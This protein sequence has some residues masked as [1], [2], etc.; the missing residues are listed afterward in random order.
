MQICKTKQNTA[1]AHDAVEVGR[2]CPLFF[3][4]WGRSEPASQ[5][6]EYSCRDV[7]CSSNLASRH[8]VRLFAL[9]LP[10][11]SI[12]KGIFCP[13]QRD[14]LSCTKIIRSHI[15]LISLLYTNHYNFYFQFNIPPLS[16]HGGRW[17]CWPRARKRRR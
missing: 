14:S 17:S 12:L 16:S 7:T 4:S 8:S 10:Y 3:F 11:F 13:G 1:G 5:S 2:A 9:I 6:R 15:Y